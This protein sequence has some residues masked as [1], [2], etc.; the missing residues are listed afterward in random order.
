MSDLSIPILAYRSSSFWRLSPVFYL[1]ADWA[2]PRA[3]AC[4]LFTI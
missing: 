2:F 4:H 3:H 1:V